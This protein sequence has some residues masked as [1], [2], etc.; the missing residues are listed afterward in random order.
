MTEQNLHEEMEARK[1]LELAYPI[2]KR[3]VAHPEIQSALLYHYGKIDFR[4]LAE[5]LD[6]AMELATV[7]SDNLRWNLAGPAE[8]SPDGD[9]YVDPAAAYNW[10][11]PGLCQFD[12]E[13]GTGEPECEELGIHPCNPGCGPDQILVCGTHL[14]LVQ[15]NN[16]VLEGIMEEWEAEKRLNQS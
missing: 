1:I 8:L 3:V 6:G 13:Y 11:E 16:K 12:D 9:S 5:L 7:D 15:E 2:I 4:L 14:R 10:T